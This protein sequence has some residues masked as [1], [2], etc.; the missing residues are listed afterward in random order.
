MPRFLLNDF[1]RYWWTVAVDFAYKQRTRFGE[2]AAI[3]NIK[4][5]M[6]RK[7]I[8]VAGLLTCFSCHA[9]SRQR[10]GEQVPVWIDYLRNR[11]RQPPLEVLAEGLLPFDHLQA[12]ARRLFDAYDGFLAILNNADARKRLEDLEPKE[13]ETDEVFQTARALSHQFR[14]G[15]LELL[16]DTKSGFA[17]L[18]KA[19]GVF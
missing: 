16:F 4:L 2:G 14:D 1:A 8:Y 12:T 10:P 9:L 13:Y 17:E 5:R 19:Y 15:L 7:M 6:S 3:R 11:L 18:T